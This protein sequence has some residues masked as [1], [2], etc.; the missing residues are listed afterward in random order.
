MQLSGDLLLSLQ[1]VDRRL[2]AKR[3]ELELVDAQLEA[4]AE[5]PVLTERAEEEREN[6]IE[7][8]A[9][10]ARLETDVDA[11]RQ[12]VDELEERIY[13]G[14]VTN[15]RELT[16]VEEEQ[17]SARRE[18]MQAEE[19]LGPARLAADDAERAREDLAATLEERATTWA[20]TAPGLRK[21]SKATKSEVE[22]LE[23][24]RAE[25]AKN[26]PAGELALYDQLL[27]RRKG[28]AV[29]RVERGVCL[30]CHI[31]LPL[32]ESSR[33]RRADALVTCGNCGRILIPS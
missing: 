14:S 24:E 1:E 21:Q 19:S 2:A 28:V 17:T 32:K 26:V 13:G 8:R 31:T 3:E 20:E 29:A 10:L 11:L 6:A 27:F 16:A 18:L 25:S 22:T 30:A 12:R 4:Q 15:L 5:I 33:L 23:A 9:H 7:R